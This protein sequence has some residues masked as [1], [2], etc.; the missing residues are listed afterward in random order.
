[1]TDFNEKTALQINDIFRNLSDE[2][3]NQRLSKLTADDLNKPDDLGYVMLHYG[4][5][6]KERLKALLDKGADPN[7]ADNTNGYT[8]LHW[9][10]LGNWDYQKIQLLLD[11]GACVYKKNNVG[12]NVIDSLKHE[13]KYYH[14]RCSCKM[15]FKCLSC[16]Q[17]NRS[18]SYVRLISNHINRHETLFRMMLE[19]VD[20]DDHEE[21]SNKRK[22]KD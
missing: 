13:M 21:C 20:I 9:A 22:R 11:Y 16:W 5:M 6:Y 7:I 17:L 10:L 18:E 19:S 2:E 1:M 12:R 8:A 15:N 4:M 14:L 3:F